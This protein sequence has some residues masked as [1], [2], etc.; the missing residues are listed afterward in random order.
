MLTVV[1]FDVIWPLATLIETV[2]VTVPLT[3][4]ESSTIAS[5]LIDSNVRESG[6]ACEGVRVRAVL[7]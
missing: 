3:T 5:T 2:S 7:G 1:E 6:H 4:V